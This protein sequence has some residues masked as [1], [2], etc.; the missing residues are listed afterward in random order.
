M[1][2]FEAVNFFREAAA[3]AEL[4]LEK[5]HT[6]CF[7]RT[8]KIAEKL[9]RCAETLAVY[10]EGIYS[11]LEGRIAYR[12][13][14]ADKSAVYAANW[15]FHIAAAATVQG[16]DGKS[17]LLVFDPAMFDGPVSVAEWSEALRM[18]GHPLPEEL[19]RKMPYAEAKRFVNRVCEETGND[20]EAFFAAREDVF[21]GKEILRRPSKWLK[22]YRQNATLLQQAKQQNY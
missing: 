1:Q 16:L 3:D 21:A 22:K 20:A 17:E 5:P 10:A 8:R 9:S 4:H 14:G 12:D 15:K 6:G 11:R 2:A 19:V 18:S 7:W 13:V